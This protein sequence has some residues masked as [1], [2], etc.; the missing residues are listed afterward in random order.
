MQLT[1]LIEKI[2]KQVLNNKN[3]YKLEVATIIIAIIAF[4]LHLTLISLSKYNL[5]NIT[6]LAD[7]NILQAISTP[8]EIILIYEAILL[9]GSIAVSIPQSVGK[10]YQVISLIFMRNIFKDVAKLGGMDLDNSL[11][12]LLF[13]MV[14]ALIMFALVAAYYFLHRKYLKICEEDENVSMKPYRTTKKLVTLL[15]LAYVM[16]ISIV[17]IVSSIYQNGIWGMADLDIDLFLGLVF[18]TLIISDVFLL[19]LSS[20]FHDKYEI[21]IRNGALIISTIIL[22]LAITGSN[23]ISNIIALFSMCFGIGFFYIYSLSR[24]I[25]SQ[26]QKLEVVRFDK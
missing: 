9:L 2:F 16:I 10:Q 25:F 13:D 18:T 17:A 8:F 23:N 20:I 15:S 21:V 7:Q 11:R 14:S 4:F 6:T 22:R 19:V 24:H 3:I 5:I 26:S 1:K 12:V